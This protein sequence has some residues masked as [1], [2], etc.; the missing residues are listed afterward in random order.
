ML[1]DVNFIEYTTFTLYNLILL[2]EFVIKLLK[3]KNVFTHIKK[4]AF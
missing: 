4:I 3:S 2:F 1:V